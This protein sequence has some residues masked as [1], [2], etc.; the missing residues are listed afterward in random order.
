MLFYHGYHVAQGMQCNICTNTHTKNILM[1]CTD[2]RYRSEEISP[3]VHVQI[4][5]V[6]ML[7]FF[8]LA[9]IIKSNSSQNL[10]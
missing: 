5:K 6:T 7:L 8:R 4:S 9:Q 2:A 1:S 10:S 3:L